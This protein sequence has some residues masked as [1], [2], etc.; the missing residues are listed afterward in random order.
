[1]YVAE[2]LRKGLGWNLALGAEGERVRALAVYHGDKN[3]SSSCC[4]LGR[5]LGLIDSCGWSTVGLPCGRLDL[6]H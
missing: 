4:K 6:A 1:M 3:L 5:L 2:D